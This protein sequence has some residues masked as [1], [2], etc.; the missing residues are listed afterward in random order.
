MAGS[1]RTVDV[2][3]RCVDN[4]CAR[5]GRASGS[6]LA[7]EVGEM[8]DVSNSL[9]HGREEASMIFACTRALSI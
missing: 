2:V 5:C 9:A 1:V 6:Q 4:E 8:G 7:A 3:P